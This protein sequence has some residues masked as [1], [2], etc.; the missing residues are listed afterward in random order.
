MI[1]V[2]RNTKKETR[3]NQQEDSSQDI[4]RSKAQGRIKRGSKMAAIVSIKRLLGD[5]FG[6][7]INQ[8]TRR[9]ES[10]SMN[11]SRTK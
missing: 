8:T 7:A 6:N 3:L 4:N 9:K 11:Q 5:I 2:Q 1:T 10:K